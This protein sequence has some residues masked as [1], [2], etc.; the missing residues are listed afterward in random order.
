MNIW[1]RTIIGALVVFWAADCLG[2]AAEE[3]RAALDKNFA[4][5]NAEDAKTLTDTLSPDLPGLRE[6]KQEAERF[7]AEEDA[8]ICVRDFELLACSGTVAKARVVQHTVTG[9]SENN[10]Y[11]QNSMLMPKAPTVEY[12]QYFK[13]VR[14]KWR[15]GLVE[16]E[17]R[18][19]KT[20][21]QAQP[22]G[23]SVFGNCANG[24]CPQR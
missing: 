22:A 6:F 8:Y 2:G 12:V 9:N 3:I 7:F 18:E 20:I 11:R 4:A 1:H 5:Y 10:G 15:L 21:A 13:R 19:V 16:A 23:R 14:G 24:T 17:P